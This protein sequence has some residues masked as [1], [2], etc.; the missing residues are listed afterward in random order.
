MQEDW[1]KFIFQGIRL[2][3]SFRMRTRATCWP[4]RSPARHIKNSRC[5]LSLS[6]SSQKLGGKHDDWVTHQIHS[7]QLNIKVSSSFR[8]YERDDTVEAKSLI[9]EK[10]I[11]QVG[12][13]LRR[14][15]ELRIATLTLT[16]CHKQL[17]FQMLAPKLGMKVGFIH[18]LYYTCMSSVV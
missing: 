18:S 11:N 7:S 17:S 4:P 10:K 14:D 15:K 3:Q 13:R 6:L 9:R 1:S 2:P 5:R 8:S 16:L 12:F